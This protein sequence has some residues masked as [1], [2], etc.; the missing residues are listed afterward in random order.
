[1]RSLIN[2]PYCYGIT[3]NEENRYL[4]IFNWY[5]Y[6]KCKSCHNEKGKEWNHF[7][8]PCQTQLF[9]LNSSNWS[10]GNADIDDIIQSSQLNAKN[11]KE[12]MEWVPFSEFSDMKKIGQGGFGTVYKATRNPFLL[13]YGRNNVVALKCCETLPCFLTEVSKFDIINRNTGGYLV[14]YMILQ[15]RAFDKCNKH[16]N[17]L[18]CHGVTFDE[19]MNKYFLILEY[20]NGGDLRKYIRRYFSNNNWNTRILNA[21]NFAKNLKTIH[22]NGFV[23][24]DLHPGNILKWESYTKITDLGRAENF[25]EA[26]SS[27]GTSG[28]YGVLPYVAPEV[29]MGQPYTQAADIYSFG[30]ILWE[31][32]SGK[33]PVIVCFITSILII[34]AYKKATNGR[35][36]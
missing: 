31:M 20:A 4:L 8:Q 27:E 33:P 16:P 28:I 2:H 3:K 5:Y 1:L 11:K 15:L 14:L 23:H 34:S 25:D 24:R 7:C 10:S 12:V 17:S 22:E 9:Q 29:L 19:N 32:S 35:D 26:I 36:P 30:M 18:K 21:L 13:S 6:N